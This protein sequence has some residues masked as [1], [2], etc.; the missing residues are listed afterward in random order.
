MKKILKITSVLLIMSFAIFAFCACAESGDTVK[1]AIVQPMS[2]PSLNQ[3]RDT[4]ISE[5]GEEY[6]GKKIEIITKDA[7]GDMS[8]LGA[9][10]SNL[11]GVDIVIPIATSAAQSAKA[12]YDGTGTPIIFAAAT[13]PA[14]AGLAGNDCDNITGVSD[15]VSPSE[16]VS[17]I[18]MIQP[19]CKKIGLVYTSSEPNSATSMAE[20]KAYLDTTSIKYE[21]AAI[22]SLSD[23]Q[24]ALEALI[25]KGVDA[26]YTNT[27]NTIATA[28]SL[29]T[30]IAYSHGMPIYCGADSM[31]ADGGTATVGVDYVT[32]GRQVAG[33]AKRVM[34]GTSPAE[35]KYEQLDSYACYI[36]MQAVNKLGI[37]I[38]GEVEG[39]LD[40]LVEADGTS[41]FNK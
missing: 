24:N 10:Y 28:M 21:E 20:V 2:H 7:S 36:N 25:D 13:Y 22:T 27:D 29:Y 37:E 5:L 26:F 11:S 17:L 19:D 9:I 12:A 4:I 8:A 33:I 31:V 14:E 3:I 41:H 40:I 39:K 23:L 35:I 6:N 34:D 18:S 32:L 38:S 16:L 15:Y 1:I 30:D